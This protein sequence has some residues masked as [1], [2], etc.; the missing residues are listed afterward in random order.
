MNTV[1]KFLSLSL[2]I[3]FCL[4]SS[5]SQESEHSPISENAKALQFQI[6]GNFTLSSFQGAAI[7]YKH[8]L[9]STSALRIGVSAYGADSNEEAA[10]DYFNNGSPNTSAEQIRDRTNINL[11]LNVQAIWYSATSSEIF[12][13]YGIGPLLS[14]G[15]TW[16]T[17]KSIYSNPITAVNTVRSKNTS[18][19]VGISGLAGVEWFPTQSI[20]VHAEY[21]TRATYSWTSFENKSQPSGTG[22]WSESGGTITALQMQSSGV[23]FGLSVYF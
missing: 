18:W 23:L 17:N 6:N 8:H 14:Y 4:F 2:L 11:Q 12:F 10:N 7:S 9:H 13:F 21:G 16:Q 19:S 20:S 15:G 1:T 3:L 5:L 22:S